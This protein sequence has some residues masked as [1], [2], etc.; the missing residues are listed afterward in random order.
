MDVIV[1]EALQF[2][3]SYAPEI[4]DWKVLKRELL[5][6]LPPPARSQFSTRD[7]LTKRQ[8]FNDFEKQVTERWRE[9]TGVDVIF[10]RS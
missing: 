6:T 1:D 8:N 9:I 2:I 3:S 10:S 7:P 4:A 5:K